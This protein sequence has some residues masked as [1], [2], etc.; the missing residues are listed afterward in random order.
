MHTEQRRR[1]VERILAESPQP[2]QRTIAS[3]LK[4][5]QATIRRDIAQLR[6]DS[7]MTQVT[8][9]APQPLP[10][11]VRSS[12]SQ[13]LIAAFDAELAEAGKAAARDLVWSAAEADVIAMIA[14]QVDRRVELSAQY[15]ACENTNTKL[16][17]ATELRL[18][19]QSITR[20]FRQVSTEVPQPM[21]VT[22]LKA[23]RAANSR[24]NRERMTQANNAT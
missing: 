3:R 23:Q 22:S 4:V 24:W 6:P 9:A 7:P 12:E 15:A 11:L 10:A 17:I 20:L 2:S 19:E 21:S 14:A 1:A 5:S 8:Q 16:K 13:A 18:T